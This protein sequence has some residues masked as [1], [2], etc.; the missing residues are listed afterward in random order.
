M[1][2]RK[3]SKSQ[4]MGVQRFGTVRAETPRIRSCT[5]CT[6]GQETRGSRRI[7]FG[8]FAERTFR[9]FSGMEKMFRFPILAA[10]RAGSDDLGVRNRGNREGRQDGCC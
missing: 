9:T 6:E 3:E 4:F 8:R 2:G 5:S 7:S 1:N 10:Q